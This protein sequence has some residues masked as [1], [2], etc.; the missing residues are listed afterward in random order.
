[1][2]K[3]EYGLRKINRGVAMFLLIVSLLAGYYMGAGMEQGFLIYDWINKM[4]NV[5]LKQPLQNYW[6]TYTIPCMVL[7]GFC[8][9]FGFL[10]LL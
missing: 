2:Q 1:M 8:Y 7:A 5:V 3:N 4:Q 9:L 10:Y 6:N